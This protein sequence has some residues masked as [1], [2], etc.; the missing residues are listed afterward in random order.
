MTIRSDVI[1]LL[2]FNGPM[3]MSRIYELISMEGTKTSLSSKLSKMVLEGDISMSGER[4]KRIYSLVSKKI[5]RGTVRKFIEDNPGLTIEQIAR[6]IPCSTATAREYIRV[7]A[8]NGIVIRKK[9]SDGEFTHSIKPESEYRF[10]CANPLT[11][12][13]NQRINEARLNK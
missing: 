4:G 3:S 7:A 6:G 12:M 1:D 2:R 13:F 5:A 10:G 8:C 9:N 11:M